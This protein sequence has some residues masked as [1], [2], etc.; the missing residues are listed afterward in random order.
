MLQ[1]AMKTL[2]ECNPSKDLRIARAQLILEEFM[3]LIKAMEDGDG[4]ETADA[5]ADLCY[6]VIGTAVA[7]GL[8][9]ESLVAE[10][11]RSNMTKE[12][13]EFKPIKGDA[14]S[15]PDIKGVLLKAK[16]HRV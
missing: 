3:E 5:V 11:H 12:I 16:E 15:P 6:V 7:F 13:G 2:Q 14:Y 4:V 9:L 10:V 1:V 8:P